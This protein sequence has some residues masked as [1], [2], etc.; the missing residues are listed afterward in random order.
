[1]FR[2]FAIA[3][4]A[5]ATVATLVFSLSGPIESSGVTLADRRV[6]APIHCTAHCPGTESAITPGRESA[7]LVLLGGGLLAVGARVRRRSR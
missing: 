6:A 7:S 1:M 5:A 4:G 3:A 2:A